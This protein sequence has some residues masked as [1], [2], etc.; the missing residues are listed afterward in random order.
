MQNGVT[1]RFYLTV[2]DTSFVVCSFWGKGFNHKRHKRKAKKRSI[3]CDFW[4]LL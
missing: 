2:V 1:L 4:T 3:F